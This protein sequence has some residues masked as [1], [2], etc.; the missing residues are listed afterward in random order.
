MKF[1]LNITDILNLPVKIMSAL[2]LASGLMLLLPAKFLK[3]LYLTPFIN[4][5]GFIIGLI[6]IVSFSILIVTLFIQIF[7][8]ISKKR[9]LKLFYK[10]AE[11]RLRKLSPYEICIVLSLFENENYTNLLPLN[12]GAVRKI[13][14]EMI[15]GKAT[16]Q[17]M[18]SDL[19]TA[20]FP[21][22]LQPWVVDELKGK[23]EL[24]DFF[25]NTV[26]DF[27][28][29]EDNQKL[30]FNALVKQSDYY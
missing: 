11:K 20:K 24:L 15:I 1:D 5:Y 8:F 7:N 26:E 29:S 27:L 4:K 25:E 14:S 23:S 12:D 22:L 13:E 9:K 3:A 19:N 16:N 21:Y 28:K 2:A 10:N 30:V 18:I 6:F 17:Y